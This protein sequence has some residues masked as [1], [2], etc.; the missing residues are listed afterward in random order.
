MMRSLTCSM[1]AGLSLI[2]CAFSADVV[3]TSDALRL[4]Q[5]GQT[6]VPIGLFGAHAMRGK[7][8]LEQAQEIGVHAYRTIN[9]GPSGSTR[10]IEREKKKRRK[11]VK[12]KKIKRQ[13]RPPL[14]QR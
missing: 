10:L 9:F 13:N 8:T 6:V 4:D 2:H 3:I 1:I 11:N 14:S 5:N 12:K 7:D